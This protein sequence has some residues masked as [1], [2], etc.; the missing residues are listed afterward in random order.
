MA[1]FNLAQIS[2]N[3][4]MNPSTGVLLA[5]GQLFTYLAGT[6]TLANTYTTSLGNVANTNPIIVNAGGFLPQ[7]VWLPA[8][9][10]YKFVLLDALSNPVAQWD[11]VYAI[12]DPVI[13]AV[14]EWVATGTPT[15]IDATHFSEVGALTNLFTVNRRVKTVN[16][17]GTFYGTVTASSYNGGTNTTTVTVVMDS[18]ALDAGLSA[19]S[20]GILDPTNTSLGIVTLLNGTR[21]ATQALNDNTTLLATDAFVLQQIANA[22][23]VGR[24]RVIN[25]DMRIDQRN[26]GAAI[27]LNNT[28]GFS[29]DRWFHN[30][31][32]GAGTGTMGVQR[33]SNAVTAMGNPYALSFSVAVANAAPSAAQ[34]SN[35]VHRIEGLNVQ[36]LLWGTASAKA[37]TLSFEFV[38]N[39]ANAVVPIAIHNGAGNRSY[40]T[41][42]T[43]GAANTPARYSVTIPGDTTGTWAI[44]TTLGLEIN[45]AAAAG[46]NFVGVAGWQAGNFLTVAGATNFM[47][48]VANTWQMTD[49][50]LEAAS[51]ATLFD[52]ISYAASMVLCRRYLPALNSGG[53]TSYIGSGAFLSGGTT[54]LINVAFGVPARIPPTGIT[55]TAATQYSALSNSGTTSGTAGPS[56][57]GASVDGAYLTLT[58]NGTAG[59]GA[60]VF[61]NNAAGQ[62]LFTGCEL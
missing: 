25:G 55:S 9:I 50:Q 20:Y 30:V 59:A 27:S 48:S 52:R 1:S 13:N 37:V 7:E 51:Q 11:N 5:G 40:L 46:S 49:V 4:F 41:T 53:T 8:G 17:G 34:F 57:T 44:D 45:F 19:V 54:M 14:T 35:T 10:G 3:Q 31:S 36:D 21:G 56:L 6:S 42:I 12:N 16:T 39:I 22:P 28:T 47:A 23:F 2:F 61:F 18:G 15:F 62:L 24:N 43:T 26:L 29:A 33:I 60:A 32:L 38:T 58:I